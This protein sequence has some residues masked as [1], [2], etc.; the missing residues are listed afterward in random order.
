MCS[1]VDFPIVSDLQSQGFKQT[2]SIPSFV[3]IHLS[4][5]VGSFFHFVLA[6]SLNEFHV[7]SFNL[8]TCIHFV[9]QA[10]KV[11]CIRDSVYVSSNQ[12]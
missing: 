10:T 4:F 1:P 6:L 9:I 7:V 8:G 12:N 5:P 3:A 2:L 11:V